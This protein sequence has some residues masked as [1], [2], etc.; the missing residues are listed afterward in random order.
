MRVV[1]PRIVAPVCAADEIAP[2]AA[3]GADELYCGYLDRAWAERWG[4]SD[5]LTRR[6]GTR[7]NVSDLDALCAVAQA[8]RQAGVPAALALNRRYTEQQLPHLLAL[9]RRWADAGGGAVI[10]ADMGLLL[11]LR[12]PGS[13]S[14]GLTVQLSLL[15]AVF[16]RAAARLFQ[17]LGVSRVIL[18]RSLT[19][20]EM[21]QL[22]AACPDLELEAMALF[23]RCQFIDGLCG[24]YHATAHPPGTR[25][26]MAYTRDHRGRPVVQR[27]DVAYAGHGCQLPFVAGRRTVTHL[28]RGAG[29]APHCAACQLGALRQAGIG[30]AKLGGRGMPVA[31][32]EQAV[33]LMA[34]A[35]D[36]AGDDEAARQRARA[37]YRQTFGVACDARRCYYPPPPEPLR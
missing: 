4:D 5:S 37:R 8:A 28:D 14:A 9:L 6:Q 23:D 24:F 35:R 1:Q 32:M 25:Q 2:L 15:A 30:F 16:N 20:A 3:A 21:A 19:L 27:W 13:G 36:D 18:P 34:A 33:G 22:H 26:D 29:R 31:Q 12:E 10:V 7:A 17:R 11:A